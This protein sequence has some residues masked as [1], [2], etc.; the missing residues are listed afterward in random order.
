MSGST[1]KPQLQRLLSF[2]TRPPPPSR[3]YLGLLLHTH[4]THH[5]C[6]RGRDAEFKSKSSH[7]ANVNG[8]VRR[9]CLIHSTPGTAHTTRRRARLSQST[10]HHAHLHAG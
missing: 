2:D 7:N 8:V 10:P 6:Y 4:R 1:P 9:W 5:G 3:P